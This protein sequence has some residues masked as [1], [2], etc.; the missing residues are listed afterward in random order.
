MATFFGIAQLEVVGLKF[1][2]LTKA[3][4]LGLNLYFYGK[5]SMLFFFPK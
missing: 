2:S 5:Y 1:D 3:S 4:F